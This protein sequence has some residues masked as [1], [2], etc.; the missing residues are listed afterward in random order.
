MSLHV[1]QLEEAA[2]QAAGVRAILLLAVL[3]IV[4]F[5]IAI[6]I[7]AMGVVIVLLSAIALVK[8]WVILMTFMHLARLWRGE[9]GH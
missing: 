9:G 8:A 5:V 4:E 1:R 7:D 6:G 2:A 3:T